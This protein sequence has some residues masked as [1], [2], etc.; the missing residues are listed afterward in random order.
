MVS[1]SRPHRARCERGHDVTELALMT[2]AAVGGAAV[3][4]HVQ[5]GTQG[6]PRR[7]A[8]A[9]G[10]HGFGLRAS[11]Y[12]PAIAALVRSN[13]RTFRECGIVLLTLSDV[14][15]LLLSIL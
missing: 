1:V 2:R 9:A 4:L 14:R 11:A 15:I 5:T 7:P 10:D 13:F 6:A 8:A 3:S 12:K